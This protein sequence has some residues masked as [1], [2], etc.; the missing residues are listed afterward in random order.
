MSRKVFISIL[1]TGFYNECQYTRDK[2]ISA[3][4]R[5]IQE[6]TLDYLNVKEWNRN[7]KIYII[8][9][10]QARDNNWCPPNNRRA[11]YTRTE[12]EYTGL[13]N[14]LESKRLE[15]QI[16]GISICNGKDEEEIWGIFKTIYDILEQEDELYIDITH[17]F[18]YLPMLLL[19]LCNY[20]SFMKNVTISSIT[21]GNFEAPQKDKPIVDLMP[22]ALLQQWTFAAAT[23]RN[24]GKMGQLAKSIKEK[25]EKQNIRKGKVAEDINVLIKQ[26]SEFENEINTC[27]GTLIKKGDSVIKIK[28][29][30][31]SAINSPI[32]TPLKKILEEV[33][34]ILEH[35]SCNNMDNLKQAIDWC[36]EFGMVQQAY[37]LAQETII[38]IVCDKLKS[39]NPYPENSKKA[40]EYVSA[41][42]GINNSMKESEWQY[43]L[44]SQLVITREINS[45][46]WV[47]DIRVPYSRLS[48]NRNQINHAGFIGNISSATIISQ[49]KK[50][51]DECFNIISKDLEIPVVDKNTDKILINLSNHPYEK[52]GDTQKEAA[53]VYGKCI[54]MPFPDIN[55]DDD[56]ERVQELANEYIGK[57][58]AMMHNHHVTVHIMGEMTFTYFVV[59]ALN[60]YNIQCIA[61]T[62]TRDVVE[63]GN[64]QK[65]VKFNF[66]RFRKY[67]N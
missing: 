18:R 4:T 38:T 39:I 32:P 30:I 64:N 24:F 61:S 45:L 67:N 7:D 62:T 6:A 17:S 59:S 36:M 2:F 26:I 35:F 55:A 33:K 1:G 52:W 66:A 43:T 31:D 50:D 27:R 3:N 37:T 57:I 9:T 41:I 25:K 14:I 44:S 54:D 10:D 29:T 47:K 20:S 23:F 16:E 56:K 21:Y 15:C 22:L 8:L 34:K 42:L 28:N 40:R 12:K 60:K 65:L 51:V 53:G 19:V 49:L 5:F 46:Q 48:G 13:K 11:D 63:T 58:K